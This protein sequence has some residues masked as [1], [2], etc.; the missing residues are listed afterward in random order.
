MCNYIKKFIL[1]NYKK[2]NRIKRNKNKE[3]NVKTTKNIHIIDY[4]IFII[5]IYFFTNSYKIICYQKDIYIYIKYIDIHDN[6]E[7][8]NGKQIHVNHF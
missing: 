1:K 3:Y 4:I 2:N 8:S 5:Y 7:I 6:F